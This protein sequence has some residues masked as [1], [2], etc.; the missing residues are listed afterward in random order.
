MEQSLQFQHLLEL[1][2]EIEQIK[3]VDV[4]LDKI[5]SSARMLVNADAGM[6][7]LV[8]HDHFER[9]VLQNH[10]L[11]QQLPP[12]KELAYPTHPMPIDEDSIMGYVAITGEMVNIPDVAHISVDE[13]LYRFH[14]Q[15]DT[16]MQY[17]AQ[18]MLAIPLKNCQ[19]KV[20]GVM[21]LINAQNEHGTVIPFSEKDIPLIRL[22]ASHAAMALE[23][24]HMEE[25]L[26]TRMVSMI[27]LRCAPGE[28]DA[29]R[30]RIAAYT[31][32][33]YTTW[34]QRR[35]IDQKTIRH[36]TQLVRRAA[37]LHDAGKVGISDNILQKP[38][39]LNA[40]ED[41]QMKQHTMEGARMLIGCQSVFEQSEFHQIAGEIAL[42]HHE[43]WDG[44]GYPGHVDLNGHVLPG[45]ADEHGNPRG[46]QGEEI[47]LFARIVAIADV[48]DELMFREGFAEEEAAAIVKSGR[49]TRFDPEM[50][51]AFM[52]CFD[53]IRS[54]RQCF[55]NKSD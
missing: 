31:A 22:F 36:Y 53:A 34:A 7:A 33:I 42:N 47:P 39:R 20:I 32:E 14:P 49:G 37:M 38:G 45:Y 29:H 2:L 21:R 46:K 16:D 10:T 8:R 35:G 25:A 23:R 9:T 3:D 44:T 27:K 41:E 19:D 12:G 26:S 15:Y 18:S 30:D 6:I 52:A 40:D 1:I 48:Y 5:L 51:D 43:H 4:L 28:T 13:V 55:P 24:T 50:V 11:Q 54:I 17:V